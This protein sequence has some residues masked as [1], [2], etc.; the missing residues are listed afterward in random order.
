MRPAAIVDGEL[1]CGGVVAIDV[2]PQCDAIVLGEVGVARARRVVG[3]VVDALLLWAADRE[4]E[5]FVVVGEL[6]FDRLE[7][8]TDDFVS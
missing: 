7:W 1:E 8:A 6:Y 4:V 3:A 2:E 5:E